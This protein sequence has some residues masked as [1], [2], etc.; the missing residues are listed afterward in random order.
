MNN[1][2]ILLNR[3]D[4]LVLNPINSS[5]FYSKEDLLPYKKYILVNGHSTYTDNKL[6][7]YL[8]EH[9][10]TYLSNKSNN[11]L[12]MIINLNVNIPCDSLEHSTELVVDMAKS[13]LRNQV[14]NEVLD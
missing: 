9:A 3:E 6:F 7:T 12:D 1:V 14:I 8:R 11:N 13:I 2:Y 4:T 10:I 5:I